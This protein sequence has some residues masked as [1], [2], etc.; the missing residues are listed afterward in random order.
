MIQKTIYMASTIQYFKEIYGNGKNPIADHI[1]KGVPKQS[2]NG[3]KYIVVTEEIENNF[4][5]AA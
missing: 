1:M 5:P 3:T 2:S 4:T